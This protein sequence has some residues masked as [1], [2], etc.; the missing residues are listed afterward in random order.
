M[1]TLLVAG[2]LTYAGRGPPAGGTFLHYQGWEVGSEMSRV[3]GIP[4]DSG[5]SSQ[6]SVKGT[7]RLQCQKPH[8]GQAEPHIA[9]ES[10]LSS[11]LLTKRTILVLFSWLTLLFCLP[12]RTSASLTLFYSFIILA[13]EEG[14]SV[15][16]FHRQ[17]CQ[18][19][20]LN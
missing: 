6:T 10:P 18:G 17:K 7:P 19:S 5:C 12:S 2:T 20:K 16:P 1:F 14:I 4:P 8:R 11:F 9:Q 15:C 3:K 13:S